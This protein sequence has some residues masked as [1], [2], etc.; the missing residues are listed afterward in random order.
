[1]RNKYIFHSKISEK[2]FRVII[3]YYSLDIEATKIAHLIGIS[4]LTIN[5]ILKAVRQRTAEF[6][7]TESPFQTGEIEIDD[8]TSVPGAYV[9]SGN[10][11]LMVNI[12]FLA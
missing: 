5:R 4:R 10:V 1:M 11:E 12:L 6:C 9:E 3:R 7:E 8:S 2:Q